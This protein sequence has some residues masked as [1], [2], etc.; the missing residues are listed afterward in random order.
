MR[1]VSELEGWPASRVRQTLRGLPVAHGYTVIVRPLRYRTRPS[2]RALCN[3]DDRVIVLSVPERFR[4]FT[5]PVY[6]GARRLPGEG[7]RFRWYSKRVTFRTRREVIRFLYCHEYFHWY[8]WEVLGR[9]SAAET[10]C[11]RFALWNFR[12]R[13]R[14]VPPV[15]IPVRSGVRV[16]GV[17]ARKGG[18]GREAELRAGTSRLGSRRLA[19]RGTG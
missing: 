11:D 8:L 19:R 10:A 3:F 15:A 7:L 9:K 2:L 13:I 4:P 5:T 18:R 1:V 16:T 6:Y 17:A 14:V 12:R